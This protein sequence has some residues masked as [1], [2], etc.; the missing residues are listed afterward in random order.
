V[1]IF[2]LPEI[3][4]LLIALEDMQDPQSNDLRA[5]LRVLAQDIWIR[6]EMHKAKE[7]HKPLVT[8]HET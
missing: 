8:L 3:R 7:S 5:K 1:N 4:R 6:E 2:T